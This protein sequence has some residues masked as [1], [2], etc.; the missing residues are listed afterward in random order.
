MTQSQV[1]RATYF[2]RR[3]AR[4]RDI[5]IALANLRYLRLMLEFPVSEIGIV[6]TALL[7]IAIVTGMHSIL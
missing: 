5:R 7:Q 6:C 1:S 2:Q 3:P 4:E